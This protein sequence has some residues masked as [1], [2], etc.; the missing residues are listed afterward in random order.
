[1]SDPRI[2][3]SSLG[4]SCPVQGEGMV[5]GRPFYFRA[6]H[7]HWSFAIATD[8]ETDPV[9]IDSPAQGFYVEEEYT[10][11]GKEGAGYMPVEEARAI[12]LRC[13]QL[14]LEREA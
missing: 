10:L 13:A 3:I 9:L 6:R 1:M 5:N 11:L 7:D 12:I 4:G 14:F 8:P 2:E